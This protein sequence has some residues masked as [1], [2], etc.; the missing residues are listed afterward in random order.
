[1]SCDCFFEQLSRTL[2]HFT[3]LLAIDLP[4]LTCCDFISLLILVV[5]VQACWDFNGVDWTFLQA[6]CSFLTFH[7]MGVHSSAP[8]WTMTLAHSHSYH[9]SHEYKKLGKLKYKKILK[10]CLVSNKM[11]DCPKTKHHTTC[12]H[13]PTAEPHPHPSSLTSLHPK[14]SQ[15]HPHCTTC[16]LISR[17]VLT[18]TSR[19]LPGPPSY[20]IPSSH[21]SLVPPPP[22]PNQETLPKSTRKADISPVSGARRLTRVVKMRRSKNEKTPA[23]VWSLLELH[24]WM[25]GV[26][27]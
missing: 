21:S 2:Q 1:L 24:G 6:L 13:S 26:R 12:S 10:N 20:P 19:S 16:I 9:V 18:R 3:T 27:K 23:Y 15:I 11:R 8:Y 5:S 4:R 25:V 14:L 17:S 22:I 7:T